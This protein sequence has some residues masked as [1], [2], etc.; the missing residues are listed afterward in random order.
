MAPSLLSLGVAALALSGNTTAVQW[1]LDDTY[2]S[3]NFFEK[4]AFI[5][6]PDTNGGYANY[7]NFHKAQRKGLAKVVDGDVVLK[8]DTDNVLPNNSTGRDSVRLESKAQLNKGLMIA[9]FSHLPQTQCGAWPAFW[10][11]GSNW[12]YEGEIDIIERWN[13]VD[14]SSSVFHMGNVTEY[15]ECKIN[16]EDQNGLVR[17]RNCD[18]GFEDGV[19]QWQGQGCAVDHLDG[20]QPGAGG[21]YAL[22]WT[23]EFIKIFSWHTDRAP[24]NLDSGSPDTST[25]GKPV[26]HLKKNSCNIDKIFR[27]QRIV[28]NIALCGNPVD[29]EYTW[30][31][32]GMSCQKNMALLPTEFPQDCRAYVNKN[33]EHFEGVYWKIKDIRIFKQNTPK[34]ATATIPTKNV[35]ASAVEATATISTKN[36]TASA[37]ETTATWKSSNSTTSSVSKASKA[38]VSAVSTG[39]SV[40]STASVA[41]LSTRWPNST[42]TASASLSASTV[43]ATSTI[44]DTSCKPT[45]TGCPSR[46][47]T[48]VIPLYVTICPVSAAET[49]TPSPQAT[50]TPGNVG[51]DNGS[52]KTTITTKVTSTYTITSC[53]TTVP[54]CTVGNTVTKVFTT[55]YCPGEDTPAPTGSNNGENGDNAPQSGNA[56]KSSNGA[57]GD[58]SDKPA[59]TI[60]ITETSTFTSCH[61]TVSKCST[62]KVITKVI[63]KTIYSSKVKGK[64]APATSLPA[65]MEGL[66]SPSSFPSPKTAVPGGQ[67]NVPQLPQPNGASNGA[68]N[69]ISNDTSTIQPRPSNS[70]VCV[71]TTCRTPNVDNGCTGPKCPPVV[72]SGAAKQGLSALLVALSAITAMML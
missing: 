10:T 8:V 67:T 25:W 32:A 56:G 70:Q 59:I 68:P 15:G 13:R 17:S 47:V 62:G 9:R 7:V 45:V 49:K 72:V 4:F 55:T 40:Y 19:T 36:V 61:P 54:S 52:D 27:N 16:D 53:A 42:V 44:T 21:V 46:V 24:K 14:K 28:F 60:Q 43:Y 23:E 65:P 11:F 12:P 3:T 64:E 37:V 1:R 48:V 57:N 39:S 69:G 34:T 6:M 50:K 33:P 20:P 41:S 31:T 63:T 22:E 38:T 58:D 66:P 18:N 2:D 71:G 51:I 29:R 30:N 26:H 35:T 5:E